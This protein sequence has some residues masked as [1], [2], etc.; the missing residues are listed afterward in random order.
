VVEDA[1]PVIDAMSTAS[2]SVTVANI[3]GILRHAIA[4]LTTS[5]DRE[6]VVLNE[7]MGNYP[8]EAGSAGAY[9]FVWQIVVGD[10]SFLFCV[11]SSVFW[12]ARRYNIHESSF[13]SRDYV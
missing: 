1:Y 4:E 11:P 5:N 9:V 7:G 3:L 6:T 2:A 13:L 10:G 12:M 8:N